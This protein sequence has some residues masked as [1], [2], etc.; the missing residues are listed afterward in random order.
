MV[1]ATISW[2]RER[3]V[4][5]RQPVQSVPM[6]TQWPRQP[7]TPQAQA[8]A[9]LESNSGA[10]LGEGGGRFLKTTPPVT[11]PVHLGGLS[12]PQPKVVKLVGIN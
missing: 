11:R 6:A 10:E 5:G 12:A 9:Q 8:G 1:C 7:S 3:Q 4:C 2:Q